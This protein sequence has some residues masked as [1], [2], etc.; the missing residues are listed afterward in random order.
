M[1]KWAVLDKSF[2]ILEWPCRC[3]RLVKVTSSERDYTFKGRANRWLS[4]LKVKYNHISSSRKS[5]I[6]KCARKTK[7]ISGDNRF[8]SNLIIVECTKLSF[9]LQGFSD[10][11]FS[12][13]EKNS[14]VLVRKSKQRFNVFVSWARVFGSIFK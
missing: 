3:F 8:I 1:L 7:K 12:I 10:Q 11:V 2:L 14:N 4:Q 5:P 13:A 9:S 6:S